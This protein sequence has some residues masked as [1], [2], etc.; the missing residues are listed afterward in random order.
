MLKTYG[1]FDFNQDAWEE[2]GSKW[3]QMDIFVW[4]GYNFGP[5]LELTKKI[6]MWKKKKKKK[7]WLNLMHAK[8]QAK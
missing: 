1:K 2:Q 3:P 4:W 6:L 7:T 8:G 5:N